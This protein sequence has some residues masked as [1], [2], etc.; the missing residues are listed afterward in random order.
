M[1]YRKKA[2]P[3]TELRRSLKK[4]NWKLA[5][6]LFASFTLFFVVYEV[7]VYYQIA[8]VIHVYAIALLILSVTYVVLA[9]GYTCK[10][11]DESLFPDNWDAS[12]RVK[13]LEGDVKRKKIAKKLLLFIIPIMLTFMFDMIYIN[14]LSD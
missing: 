12:R 9:R 1:K 3:Q 8:Y 13:Y 10:P 2:D 4:V 6:Q 11:F 5:G 14:F 7:F